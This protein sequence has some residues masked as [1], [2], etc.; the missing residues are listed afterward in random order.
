M[1]VV[2]LV[3]IV[4]M[5]DPNDYKNVIEGLIEEKTGLPAN[6]EGDIDSTLFPW[7]GG[8]IGAV[9][10][11]NPEG[12]DDKPMI[13]AERI[14]VLL[15]LWPL[16][17]GVLKADDIILE[18]AEIVLVRNKEGRGNWETL[19]KTPSEE[20]PENAESAGG[21]SFHFPKIEGLIVKNARIIFED[22][23]DERRYELSDVRIETGEIDESKPFSVDLSMNVDSNAPP[24]SAHLSCAAEAAV[25]PAEHRVSLEGAKISIDDIEYP[26]A[27]NS[28]RRKASSLTGK[29]DISG[30]CEINWSGPG[31]QVKALTIDLEGRKGDFSGVIAVQ[32]EK[33]VEKTS[34][35]VTK[36]SDLTV[37]ADLKTNKLDLNLDVSSSDVTADRTK[38]IVK[39]LGL[40]IAGDVGAGLAPGEKTSFNLTAEPVWRW[41]EDTLS[42]QNIKVTLYSEFEATGRLEGKNLSSKA[43]WTGN[44]S[45]AECSPRRLVQNMGVALPELRGSDVLQ[46]F[47]ADM[48]FSYEGEGLSLPDIDIGVD[49]SRINGSIR[50]ERFN[51]VNA[52]FHLDIDKIDL[53][54]YLPQKRDEPPDQ[55]K[56]GDSGKTLESFKNAKI[57][58]DLHAGRLTVYDADLNDVT[59]KLSVQNGR[60]KI[61][62]ITADFYGGGVKSVLSAGLYEETSDMDVTCRFSDVNIGRL[63]KALSK[64]NPIKKGGRVD[65]SFQLAGKGRKARDILQDADGKGSIETEEMTI[66]G[67]NIPGLIELTGYPFRSLLQ[68]LGVSRELPDQMTIKPVSA[69]FQVKKGSLAAKELVL[70]TDDGVITFDGDLHLPSMTIDGELKVVINDLAAIP[71][72]ITGSVASPKLST[73]T[74]GVIL[75]TASEAAASPIELG[76]DIITDPE[77]TGKKILKAPWGIGAEFIKE[78]IPGVEEN[79]NENKSQ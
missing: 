40:D 59:V 54:R 62:P 20:Q 45:V 73:N 27:T 58:G 51:P 79:S 5:V 1:S 66:K 55:T 46:S 23:R 76:K 2:A 17:N 7:I 24:L 13:R 19:K 70:K 34:G 6:I 77:E 42:V 37:N 16:L 69:D 71:M 56:N 68:K 32:S 28:T 8:V 53:N 64:Q 14:K 4:I 63:V 31:I 25:Y 72:T 52:D 57:A 26:P 61:D 44:L 36:L 47:F 48:G 33:I 60:I 43:S 22:R 21:S 75:N 74:A 49:G 39:I 67:L 29:T 9:S 38:G 10:L 78:G 30:N 11:G 3:L 35:G 18:N 50:A 12:F 15:K 65:L 41:K